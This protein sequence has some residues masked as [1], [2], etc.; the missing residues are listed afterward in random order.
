MFGIWLNFFSNIDRHL[1]YYSRHLIDVSLEFV[2]HYYP[3][4]WDCKLTENSATNLFCTVS[5]IFYITLSTNLIWNPFFFMEARHKTF[6]KSHK[7]YL[8]S[9]SIEGKIVPTSYKFEL[10]TEM[11]QSH[12]FDYNSLNTCINLK[13]KRLKN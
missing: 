2:F 8:I 4:N 5:S 13:P 9:T 10:V 3:I 1:W 11:T 7:K 12:C 6:Y